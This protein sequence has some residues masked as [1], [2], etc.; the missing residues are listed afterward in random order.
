MRN[1]I[2]TGAN[3]FIGSELLNELTGNGYTVYAVVRESSL[4]TFRSKIGGSTIPEEQKSMIHAVSGDLLFPDMIGERLRSLCDSYQIFFHM[5]W[6]GSAGTAR[7]DLEHQLKNVVMTR[8]MVKLA[9]SL[10][11]R[12]FVGAGSIMEDEVLAS[13]SIRGRKTTINQIYSSAKLEAHLA[14][15][16]T[17]EHLGIDFLWGKITNAY[18]EQD[19]TGRF[20]DNFLGKMMRGEPCSFSKADQLYDF[21]HISDAAKAFRLIGEKGMNNASYVVGSGELLRLKDYIGIMAR[22][23]ST[24][25]SL[26]FSE[27]TSSICYLPEE[28]FNTADLARDTGYTASVPFREGIASIIE[29]RKEII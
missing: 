22:A 18:G 16:I 26:S 7:A 21:V 13:C 24:S 5:A 14:A 17:A 28:A 6:D 10:N 20:V 15:R 2:I 29:K 19:H 1:V 27:D 8:D 4:D 9:A 25:S 23:A 3:G 11:C 12:R